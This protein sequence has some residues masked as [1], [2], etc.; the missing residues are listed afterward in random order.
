MG[1]RWSWLWK[2]TRATAIGYHVQEGAESHDVSEGT[3]QEGQPRGRQRE[4]RSESWAPPS[5]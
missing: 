3:F 5:P 2:T 1:A 4:E